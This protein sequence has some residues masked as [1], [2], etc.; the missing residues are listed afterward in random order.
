MKRKPSGVCQCAPTVG[1]SPSTP[2]T[3]DSRPASEIVR[4]KNGSVSIRPVR[5]STTSVSWCSHP[6]WFSSEPW[7]WSIVKRTVPVSRA[8]APRYTPD[9]PQYE[10]ISNSAPTVPPASP[11]SCSASPSSSGMKP[12][13]ARATFSSMSV[14]TRLEDRRLAVTA[15]D[16]GHR[17]HGLADGCVRTRRVE[18]RGHHVDLGVGGIGAQPG[19]GPVDG[20]RVAVGLHRREPLE[21]LLLALPTDLEDVRRRLVVA[22]QEAGDADHRVAA[23]V[24]LAL[25]V[26][27][28]LRDLALIPALLDRDERAL[29]H[30]AASERVDVGE[31]R[32]GLALHLVGELLHEPR[33]A[34]RVGHVGH[35][36]LVRDHLLGA[37]CEAGGLVG[38]EGERLV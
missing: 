31:D 35:A 3:I 18:Q 29:E 20:L 17:V 15:E 7:W 14:S 25:E 32:L 9:L 34:Q 37:Q 12:F 23:V 38:G 27:G 26:V 1:E 16:V 19:G 11:A 5:G 28:G 6:A 8:A 22:L 30:R 21:L 2:I 4:R 36:G 13:A 10:P 24:E 33:A